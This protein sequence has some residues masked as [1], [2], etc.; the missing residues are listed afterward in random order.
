M[1]IAD[2]VQ[3]MSA[4]A[5]RSTGVTAQR[6]TG[7][8]AQ[9][10]TGVTARRSTGV[11]AQRSTGVTVRRSTGVTAQRSTG[12]TS[13]SSQSEDMIGTL[14]IMWKLTRW[15]TLLNSWS[16]VR[17]CS[18]NSYTHIIAGVCAHNCF[19]VKM[20]CHVADKIN[21]FKLKVWFI[22][23]PYLTVWGMLKDAT[24][25]PNASQQSIELINCLPNVW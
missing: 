25:G 9:R 18:M 15:L 1:M 22:V 6:S 20:G 2:L 3:C 17:T 7:V 13:T 19:V 12:V 21:T 11:T 4:A 8:T 14:W 23:K 24:V 10:S 16:F 5:L